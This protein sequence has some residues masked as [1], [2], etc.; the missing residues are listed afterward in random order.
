VTGA[1]LAGVAA[2]GLAVGVGL[3]LVV[4]RIPHRRPV[5]AAG[6]RRELRPGRAALLGALCAALFAGV[7]ARV[8]D[9][10]ALP[11]FLVLAAALPALALI[12]LEHL[13]LPNRI[14][15]PVTAAVAALLALG[16]LADDDLGALTRALAA[17]ACSFGAFLVL[18]LLSPRSLGF[19]DVKLVF[20]L[21]L[22]LGWLGWGELAGGMFLAFLSGAVVGLAL[23]VLAGRDRRAHLSFGPFLAAG[24]LA[25]VVWGDAILGWSGG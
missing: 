20:V 14:V 23:V 18:H 9:S 13:R 10:W 2:L 12:D 5:L 11:A 17:G 6:A 3:D 24:T 19:G 21:G 7:A 4:T 25:V 1:G 15:Y 8:H 22:A 16:S